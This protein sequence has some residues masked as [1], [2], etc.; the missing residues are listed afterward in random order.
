MKIILTLF[1][2]SIFSF[3]FSQR[4]KLELGNYSF[5]YFN[6]VVSKVNNKYVFTFTT[7]WGARESYKETYFNPKLDILVVYNSKNDDQ[8]KINVNAQSFRVWDG[9]KDWY[10]D[11][12]YV[13]KEWYW[14]I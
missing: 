9:S 7:D 2:V 8:L 14:K 5:D 12:P 11:F 3:L 6:A 4:P 1:L 13:W 10:A